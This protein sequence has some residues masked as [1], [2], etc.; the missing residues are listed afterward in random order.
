MDFIIKMLFLLTDSITKM[1]WLSTF[2]INLQIDPTAR[3]HHTF[4]ALRYGNF[5]WF[6]L[7]PHIISLSK[8]NQVCVCVCV[9]PQD[10]KELNLTDN[11]AWEGE[12]RNTKGDRYEDMHCAM[13][14]CPVVGLEMN[15]KHRYGVCVLL[16]C[17]LMNMTLYTSIS[18]MSASYQC[19]SMTSVEWGILTRKCNLTMSAFWGVLALNHVH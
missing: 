5:P 8:V 9:I 13:F 18:S 17:A 19:L 7:R 14:I 11:P 4:V 16:W 10:I 15:G 2:W 6:Q 1:L 3:L 12:R